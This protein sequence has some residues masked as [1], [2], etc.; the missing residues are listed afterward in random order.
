[1]L[2]SLNGPSSMGQWKISSRVCV[3]EK[4]CRSF[5]AGLQPLS[6]DSAIAEFLHSPPVDSYRHTLRLFFKASLKVPDTSPAHA[7]HCE[8]SLPLA[9]VQLPYWSNNSTIAPE[10]R[11]DVSTAFLS[12]WRGCG[13]GDREGER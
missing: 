3:S 7:R 5:P 6:T 2:V 12:Y 11:S 9:V 8:P 4:V 1:M 13:S 10:R